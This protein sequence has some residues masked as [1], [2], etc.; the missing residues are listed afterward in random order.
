MNEMFF[1]SNSYGKSKSTGNSEYVHAGH[2]EKIIIFIIF[3]LS[4]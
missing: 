1:K 2:A 3:T 4:Y